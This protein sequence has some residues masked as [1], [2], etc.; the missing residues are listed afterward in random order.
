MDDGEFGAKH[1]DPHCQEIDANPQSGT[2]R[3]SGHRADLGNPEAVDGGV[4]L[5]FAA[6]ERM[7]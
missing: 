3:V 4:D 2:G 5:F 6:V 7:W 1:S